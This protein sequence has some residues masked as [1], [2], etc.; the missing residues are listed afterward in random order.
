MPFG[1][2]VDEKLTRFVENVSMRD[3][4]RWGQDMGAV[5]ELA[6]P[7][8]NFLAEDRIYTKSIGLELHEGDPNVFLRRACGN[9]RGKP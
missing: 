8:D 7:M 2:V 4:R 1:S 9:A 6:L 3:K 5:R